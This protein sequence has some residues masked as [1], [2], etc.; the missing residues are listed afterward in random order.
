MGFG[1]IT[2]QVRSFQLYLCLALLAVASPSFGDKTTQC[3]ARL[4]ELAI[5]VHRTVRTL[6]GGSGPYVESVIHFPGAYYVDSIPRF[7]THGETGRVYAVSSDLQTQNAIAHHKKNP[8]DGTLDFFISVRVG[9]PDPASDR[10]NLLGILDQFGARGRE[11][12]GMRRN[13]DAKRKVR[14]FV[15]GNAHQKGAEVPA[16]LISLAQQVQT[17]FEVDVAINNR[18]GQMHEDGEFEVRGTDPWVVF[19]KPGLE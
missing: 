13:P 14:I 7:S 5:S 17:E 12:R 18:Y 10:L 6:S 15:V 11:V 3:D 1:P 2:T 9:D 8:Q 16:E 4:E 19:T